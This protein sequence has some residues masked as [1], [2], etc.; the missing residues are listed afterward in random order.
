MYFAPLNISECHQENKITEEV[1]SRVLI[2]SFKCNVS[3]G[4][5]ETQWHVGICISMISVHHRSQLRWRMYFSFAGIARFPSALAAKASHPC[6]KVKGR[7]GEL[8]SEFH[9]SS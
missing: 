6:Q 9:L 3:I 8:A 1:E 7:V 4:I 5:Y 2:A